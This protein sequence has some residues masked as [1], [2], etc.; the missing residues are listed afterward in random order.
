MRAAT[1]CFL[2]QGDPPA[3]V[4]MGYKKAGFGQGKYTGFGGK[5]ER[6]ESVEAAARRE[7]WEE[8]G[9]QVDRR[10]FR[11]VGRLTFLFPACPQWS[12][13]VHVFLATAWQGE[14][15]ESDEMKPAW[16]QVDDLPFERM[17]QDG[18]H[19]LPPILQ[20]GRVAARFVFQEDNETIAEVEIA[21]L[22]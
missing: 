16:F 10:S 8:S 4:L 17:W 6:G 1:L 14:P 7:M 19:W 9:V 18:A 3:Q 12:Q 22:E 2:V 20:G 15:L 11:R 13:V 5:V 21:D